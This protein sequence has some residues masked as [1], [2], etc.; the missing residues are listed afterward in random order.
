MM[1]LRYQKKLT[2]I[3]IWLSLVLCAKDMLMVNQAPFGL[4]FSK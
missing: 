4:Q 2:N 1:H 3:F